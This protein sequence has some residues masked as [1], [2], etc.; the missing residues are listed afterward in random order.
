MPLFLHKSLCD[1]SKAS[2]S[3]SQTGEQRG[4]DY[5]HRIQ[6]GYSKQTNAPTYRYFDTADEWNSYTEQ[7]KKTKAS[8]PK[9]TGEESARRL[10]QKTEQEHKESSKKTK[11]SLF[12]K[13]K[14]KQIKKSLF[15]LVEASK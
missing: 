12:I 2:P 6:T 10:K 3:A 14:D 13:D 5:F 1:M 9:K 15:I 4:G 11:D 7:Q 8:K